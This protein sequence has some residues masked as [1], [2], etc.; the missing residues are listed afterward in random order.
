M[1]LGVRMG[2]TGRSSLLPLAGLWLTAAAVLLW[3][4]RRRSALEPHE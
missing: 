1:N 4:D 3:L 2:L